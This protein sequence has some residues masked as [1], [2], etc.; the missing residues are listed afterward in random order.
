MVHVNLMIGW[1][2]FRS[3]SILLSSCSGWVQDF[4]IIFKGY[5]QFS[6]ASPAKLKAARANMD[7]LLLAVGLT[8]ESKS[9]SYDEY[10]QG[11]ATQPINELGVHQVYVCH[12]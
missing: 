5:S 11:M 2:E 10:K 1:K 12:R 3:M 9:V 7:R 6:G 8:D 4:D